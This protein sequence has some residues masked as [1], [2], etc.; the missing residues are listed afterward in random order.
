MKT[1]IGEILLDTGVLLLGDIANLK[2]IKQ[3]KHQFTRVFKHID[4]ETLYEQGKDFK[5]FTDI[6]L[7]EMSINELIEKEI[8]IEQKQLN[9]FDLS[10]ENILNDLESGF[11][12]LKF[13]TGINGKAFAINSINGEGFYPV[14]AEINEKGIERIIIDFTEKE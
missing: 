5:K 9:E 13:N 11:K 4:T 6:L 1:K 8:L 12:Q 2:K 10:T 3:D 14:Y 7:N